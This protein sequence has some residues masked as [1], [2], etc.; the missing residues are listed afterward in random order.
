MDRFLREAR[1]VAQLNHPHIV[2][3][4]EFAHEG[5]TCYLVYAFVPGMTLAQ[6]LAGGRAPFH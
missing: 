2:S 1:A 3:I 6:R 5:K 4:H